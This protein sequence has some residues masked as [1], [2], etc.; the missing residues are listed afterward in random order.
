MRNLLSVVGALALTVTSTVA[1]GECV[2]TGPSVSGA[3]LDVTVMKSGT[4][5]RYDYVIRNP[6]SS[7]GCVYGASLDVSTRTSGQS[8]STTGG[9]ARQAD[10]APFSPV[11]GTYSRTVIPDCAGSLGG[12]GRISWNC[13]DIPVAGTDPVE[14]VSG[15]KAHPG[16]S[17]DAFTIVSSLPP[18]TRAY[19]LFVDFKDVPNP[20]V[21]GVTLGP[22]EPSE[23]Q[24]YDGGGQKPVDV[25]LFLTY[26]NPLEHRTNVTKTAF[27][28]SVRYGATV[29]AS[30]FKAMLN[31]VGITSRV[32]PA[33]GE[34]DLVTLSLTS[35]SNTLVLSVD[36]K[37][38]GGRV[39]TD[40]DRL[41]LIAP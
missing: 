20:E 11:R 36:G 41:V 16:S 9:I 22:T 30:T 27:P 31:G 14:F 12:I 32:H 5:F 23:M 10:V 28:L 38:A 15:T 3:T 18:A 40:T 24:T 26:S 29:V 1:H 4:D 7:T 21:R 13:V 2:L 6:S 39:A 17:L 34:F 19:S 8:V 25:N 35:G 37:T 33:A